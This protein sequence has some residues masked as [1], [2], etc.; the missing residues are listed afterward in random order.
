MQRV[1]QQYATSKVGS[2]I[3]GFGILGVWKVLAL[4]G[5]RVLGER[6]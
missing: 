3:D 5:P 2:K 1:L 4:E 6:V